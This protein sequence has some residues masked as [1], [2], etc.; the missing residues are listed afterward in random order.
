MPAAIKL[1]S[2][3]CPLASGSPAIGNARWV[4]DD[5][6]ELHHFLDHV[7]LNAVAMLDANALRL[8]D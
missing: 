3:M 8:P 2:S 1:F 7:W 4:D 5:E 6:A